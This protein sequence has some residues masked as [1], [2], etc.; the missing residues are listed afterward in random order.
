MPPI[1]I[2]TAALLGF[3]GAGSSGSDAPKH[4]FADCPP[5]VRKTFQAETKG[6]K[7][8][9]VTIEKTEDETV[10]WA[11]VAV[12]ERTYSIGVLADGT[13]TEMNLAI[14]EDKVPFDRCP[15]AV[16]ATLK[17]EA[18]GEKVE[19]VGKDTNY[20]VSV[21]EVA[22]EHKGRSY[23]IVVAEDGTLVEKVLV[24]DDE[25]I[26]LA[27]CPAA[28][29]AAFREHAKGGVIAPEITRSAGIIRP[30]YE[31][32]VQIKGTIYLIEVS[33]N[34]SLISKSLEAAEQ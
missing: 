17:N 8:E 28:V 27:K 10:F 12:G 5:A 16:R 30:T 24:I 22:V 3:A 23:Q 9:T 33:E 19:M 11:D 1:G 29:Q 14:D 34:G 20:G 18:F 13:L 6:A 26:A 15:E 32:E 4:K 2:M 7:I 31:V 21:Y 25:E